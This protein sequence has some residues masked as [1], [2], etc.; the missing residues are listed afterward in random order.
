MDLSVLLG[1]LIAGVLSGAGMWLLYRKRGWVDVSP[2]LRTMPV[3]RMKYLPAGTFFMGAAIAF[4]VNCSMAPQP[5]KSPKKYG[6]INLRSRESITNPNTLLHSS[7]ARE[8]IGSNFG[9][10]TATDTMIPGFNSGH[11]FPVPSEELFGGQN[12]GRFLSP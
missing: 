5:Q 4:L 11:E 6:D 12:A 10:Q 9:L 1:L 3:H 7:G 2:H 8:V